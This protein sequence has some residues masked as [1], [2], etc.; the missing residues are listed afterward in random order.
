[1][2]RLMNTLQFK[3]TCLTF[4]LVFLTC[5]FCQT[6][7]ESDYQQNNILNRESKD[8]SLQ[9]LLDETEAL[10]KKKTSDLQNCIAMMDAYNENPCYGNINNIHFFQYFIFFFININPYLFVDLHCYWEGGSTYYSR[11]I[12]NPVWFPFSL[13]VGSN[14][15]AAKYWLPSTPLI[16]LLLIR[17]FKTLWTWNIESPLI[18]IAIGGRI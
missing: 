6:L 7:Y 14:I 16:S 17:E 9:C 13:R 4:S 10:L 15:I 3:T 11:E 18:F 2:S 8:V 1:M 12:L 5:I